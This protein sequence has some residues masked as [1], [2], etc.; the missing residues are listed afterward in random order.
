MDVAKINPRTRLELKSFDRKLRIHDAFSTALE[1]INECRHSFI[2]SD[3]DFVR[4]YQI[5]LDQVEA[6]FRRRF[7]PEIEQ[8]DVG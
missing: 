5:A 6:N 1:V 4:G 8:G 3:T 7:L 2:N